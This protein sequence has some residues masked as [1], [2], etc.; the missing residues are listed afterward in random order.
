MDAYLFERLSEQA[1]TTLS[2]NPADAATS[3]RAALS[4]WRGRPFADLIDVPGLQDEIRRIEEMRLVALEARIDADL[5]TGRHLALIGELEALATAHPLREGLRARH[6]TALYRGGRQAEALRVYQ[7]TR[8]YL[9]EELGVDP[10]PELQRV[11][12]RILSH[13][14]TLLTTHDVRTE[15]VTFLFTDVEGS[16]VLWETR[17]E[18]MRTALALHDEIITNAIAASGGR[19]FKHTGDGVLAAFALASDAATAAIRAQTDLA[20]ADWASFDP[21]LVRMSIDS[22]EVESRGGDYFGPP[23]NRNARLMDSAHGGQIVISGSAQQ[24]LQQQVGLQFRNL[25]EHRFRGLG[26]PQSVFQLIVPGLADEFPDLRVDKTAPDASRQFGD[27][28]RGY[29][30]R[31]RIGVG[32]FA[33]V[34]RAYQPSIGREV[35]VKV[36]RPE[37]ANHPGFVRRFESE[38]RLVA[39][40]E[41]PHIVSLYDFWRD[42]EGRLSGDA[43]SHGQE[44]GRR[45]LRRHG[46]SSGYVHSWPGRLSVGLRPQAR[47]GSSRHQAGQPASRR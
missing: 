13:D 28:I 22:G 29:E 41:H 44:S 27:A 25:G 10:S 46:G 33:V 12:D 21:L 47:G 45:S 3:L 11:E 40:L 26:T 17:P 35:A 20:G 36:I 34:Y 16:T 24:E 39:K 8:E 5:A 18:G 32:R 15:H 7:R 23:L 9:A 37:F 19:I 6:M 2:T 31:E 4:L 43:L 14:P 30:L 42:P 38:A 1:R